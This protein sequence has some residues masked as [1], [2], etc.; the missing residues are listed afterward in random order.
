M[1]NSSPQAAARELAR[2]LSGTDE[3][4]L[5]WD[6]VTDRVALSVRDLE[7]GIGFEI[8]VRPESALG[9]FYHSYAYTPSGAKTDCGSPTGTAIADGC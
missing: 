4:R 2:R 3:V 8:A 7:T 6:P 1:L 5:V 9:A